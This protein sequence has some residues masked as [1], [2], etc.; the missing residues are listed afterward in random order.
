VLVDFLDENIDRP[1]A[2]GAVYNGAGA[3]DAQH[4]EMAAGAGAATGNANTWFRGT[5]VRMPILPCCSA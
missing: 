1:V 4:N 5:G 2:I 3:Q